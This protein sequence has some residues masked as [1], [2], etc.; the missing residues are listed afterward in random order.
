MPVQSKYPDCTE[1]IEETIDLDNEF[2]TAVEHI[3]KPFWKSVRKSIRI[4]PHFHLKCSKREGE[5]IGLPVNC[6]VASAAKSTEEKWYL[7]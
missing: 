5:H 2:D 6:T 7:G 1:E 3:F 4:R